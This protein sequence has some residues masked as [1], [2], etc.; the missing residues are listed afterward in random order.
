LVSGTADSASGLFTSIAQFLR[1]V[2]PENGAMGASA[3]DPRLQVPISD[4]GCLLV[5]H[6]DHLR[7]QSDPAGLSAQIGEVRARC[8]G[9]L[10]VLLYRELDV[11]ACGEMYGAGL[12]A[13]LPVPVRVSQ[14]ERLLARAGRIWA[15]SD[16]RRLTL[17]EAEEVGRRLRENQ[18]SLRRQVSQ[19]AG[20][21]GQAQASLERTNQELT[22]HMAQLSLLYRFGRELSA[23][24]NWDD[25]LRHILESLV[26]FV[27]ATGA[28]VILRASPSGPY[29]PR[30][31]FG[32]EEESWDKVLVDMEQ[33][34]R[35]DIAE[36]ILAPNVFHLQDERGGDPARRRRIV[37]LPLEQ[38]GQR[39]GYLLLLAGR[40]ESAGEELRAFLPFL[41]AVQVI[42][43]EE[44]AGAQLLDRMREIGSFNARVLETVRSGIWVIDEMGR[45][46]TCNCT[47]RRLISDRPDVEGLPVD[48]GFFIG[49]GRARRREPGAAVGPASDDQVPEDTL[50]ELFLDGLLQLEDLEGLAL[51]Q[52]MAR[53]ERPYRGQGSILR[54]D[55][56]IIPVL[57]QTSLMAGRGRD[58][59]WLVVVAEDLRETKKL[60]AE[61]MRADRLESLVEMST[62]LAHEIRNPLMGLSAQAE[63][64]AGHLPHGDRRK[65][66][67]DVIISEV[68]RINDT[69]NRLLNFV[70]PY[71]PKLAEVSL[72]ELARDC[73]DLVSSRAMDKELQVRLAEEPAGLSDAA[74]RHWVD[75]GQIKQVLLNLLLNAIDASP[76]QS[77]VVL[78]LRRHER[79]EWRDRRQGTSQATAGAILEVWDAGAGLSETDA[80]R[81]FRPFYTTKS[82]GTGLGLSISRK[83]VT[84]HRGEIRLERRDQWTV[85]SVL[86]PESPAGQQHRQEAS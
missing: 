67:L 14:W 65:R 3:K 28:A 41:Q 68:E 81:I 36:R 7:A 18:E 74:W 78:R 50:P 47:G 44:V 70:R 25:T 63:L 17:Q 37:I 42:L 60:E 69:I 43:A 20:E 32:W 73:L 61:R 66:Y 39:L 77:E 56:Q 9:I 40:R 1:A 84:A 6:G 38:Q 72:R 64:L 45:T 52:L 2:S 22:A 82:T 30:Q 15:E 79:M 55:G 5:M 51:P 12:F 62:A 85:F 34:L 57:V 4:S 75:G 19:L 35:L 59:K 27:G 31:T 46:I 80:A 86:L 54:T 8:P 58:E 33:Q 83:I 13:A 16:E 76:R 26:E 29:A 21:L 23:A 11:E 48:L 49:R 53:G 71:E 10:P 24:R